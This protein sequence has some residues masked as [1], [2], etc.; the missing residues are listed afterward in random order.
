M[1]TSRDQNAGRS[2]NIRTDNSSFERVKESKH[3]GKTLTNQT[4]ILEQI[5]IRLNT[6]N[7]CYHSAQNLFSFSLLPKNIKFKIYI[8]IILTV[9]FMGVELGRRH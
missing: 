4:Y 1:V 9:V 2:H 6:G 8:N 5:K 7:A 3:L